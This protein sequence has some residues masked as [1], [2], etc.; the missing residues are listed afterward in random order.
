M[1]PLSRIGVLMMALFMVGACTSTSNF[2]GGSPSGGGSYKVGEPYQVKGIWY[3]PNENYSYD[4]TGIASWYGGDFHGQRTSNGEVFDSNELTAAHPT[5]PMPSLARVTNLEN[6]RSIVVRINDRGPFS[7]E[8]LTD[9]SRRVAQLLG[10]EKKGTAKVRLQ[11]LADESRAIAA[12][13]RRYGT[14]QASKAYAHSTFAAA[15]VQPVAEKKIA[16]SV[17]YTPPQPPVPERVISDEKST[18]QEFPV[19]T[20]VAV[21]PNPQIYVQAGAFTV[22]ENAEKLQKELRA[23][24]TTQVNRAT[25]N[26]TT[27]YR[28]RIGPVDDVEHANALLQRVVQRGVPG[29]RIIV[30]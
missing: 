16:R 3:Y 23:L 22:A 4:E 11:V 18:P 5:L 1:I 25:I 24:G 13:A 19:M 14:G 12:A 2:F 26:A 29:A 28:V 6:G 9:V 17:P 15:P 7:N 30:D 10:F 27:F 20:Q 8:R 21:K